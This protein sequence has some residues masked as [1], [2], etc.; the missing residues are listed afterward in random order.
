MTNE[1]WYIIVF[2]LALLVLWLL[3]KV[4]KTLAKDFA[5]GILI[6]ALILVFIILM[7][8]IVSGRSSI[9]SGVENWF[10]NLFR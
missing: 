4:F 10:E 1:L 3:T 7:L 8:N 6:F 2:I 9:E 5:G